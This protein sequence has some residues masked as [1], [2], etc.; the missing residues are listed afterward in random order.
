MLRSVPP[1][2]SEPV[3]LNDA[4]AMYFISD[5][6]VKWITNANTTPAFE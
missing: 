5:N 1:S 3:E 6:D 2:T 4:L